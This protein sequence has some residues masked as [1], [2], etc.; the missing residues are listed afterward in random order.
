[1]RIILI[2]GVFIGSLFAN[3]YLESIYDNIAIKSTKDAI[4]SV[5]KLQANVK[6]ENFKDVVKSWKRVEAFYILADLNDEYI[7]IPRYIDIFHHGNEDI[8]KQ[9]DKIIADKEDLSIS[10]Y[11]N[12]H[13]G[14][15]ALE[16]ILFTK[17]VSNKRVADIVR[18]ITTA[19][20]NNLSEIHDGY[21][22]SRDE[23]IKD[24][25]KSKCYY[26]KFTY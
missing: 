23:F 22:A 2:L 14:I 10:L 16:Y 5:Q 3:E 13:K 1:M 4:K 26:V 6:K 7:D 9:L 25:K 19:M 8:T 24:E 12:S 15:N 18:I 11:K 17:D 20:I 21:A